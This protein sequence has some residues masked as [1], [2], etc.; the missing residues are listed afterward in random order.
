MALSSM[1]EVNIPS[2]LTDI[3]KELEALLN[4]LSGNIA[5]WGLDSVL[6]IMMLAFQVSKQSMFLL[7]LP[8][9]E[10]FDKNLDNFSGQYVF[11]TKDG[12]VA[13]SAVFRDE[14]M[15]V[16]PHEIDDWDVKILFKDVHAFWE[17]I[18]AGGNDVLDSI[19][20]NEVEV[21]GNL[22]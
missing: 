21:Y 20:E 2:H 12:L 15:D 8:R 9:L 1:D 3:L 17:F 19:L 22:N 5:N 10:G 6:R 4:N 11:G 13:R 7:V 18:F 16:L 14:Q